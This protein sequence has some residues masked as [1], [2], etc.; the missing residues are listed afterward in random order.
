[1]RVLQINKFFYRRGGAETVFF[2]TITGLRARGHEVAEW[3]MADPQ[4]F[5]SEFSAYFISQLPELLH[6]NSLVKEGEIFT[7]LFVSREA[8][9]KLSALLLATEPEV[10]HLHNV[11]HHL[12]ASTFTT[13]R[14]RGVPMVLT[15]HDVFPLCPNH[16]LLN[17]ETIG[18]AYFKNKLYNCVRYRCINNQF[19][20]SLAGTLEAY[21]YRYCGI[22]DSIA[23]FICPSEF[24]RAKMVEYG[25]PAAK[26]R[27]ARNPFPRLPQSQP[28][29]DAVMYLGRL[30][31]EKGLKIFLEA[32]RE[33][34]NQPVIIAGRGPLEG[35]VNTYCE[36]YSL[37]QVE[38][39]GWVDGAKKEALLARARVVVAP[40]LFYE[41]CSLTI[42]E[43]ISRG[44]LV[45][46]ADRG[47]N[48]EIIQ[49]GVTGFLA[50]PEDPADLA[51]A[52]KRALA[53]PSAEASAMIER[54]RARLNNQHNPDQ[55]FAALEQVY[56][57][58]IQGATKRR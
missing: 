20:P 37:T 33:L 28:L 13:L 54:A 39:V 7:R 2:D 17:G 40:S 43:A 35:W 30:H 52:I 55:Y 9:A 5:P 21:Y 26:M 14:R 22:W 1:M 10:A 49:D 57:E 18:D 48:G 38:R 58:A 36:R 11:Y 15:L 53:L 31:A 8:K 47:G 27:L 6:E 4:N 51:R 24:M 25:F 46:A 50:R 29:G 34:Y 45:V 23:Y 41:N 16:S 3:S 12:S 56:A 32:T 44:R 42:L 19:W